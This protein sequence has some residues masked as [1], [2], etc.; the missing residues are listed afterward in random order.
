MITKL[1]L[2]ALLFSLAGCNFI[3]ASANTA[4]AVPP[5]LQYLTESDLE[6]ARQLAQAR[7]SKA[8]EDA[9]SNFPVDEF[10]CSAA[11]D[12]AA[13]ENIPFREL[14]LHTNAKLPDYH[15]ELTK[16]VFVSQKPLLTREECSR[17]I[18]L[19]DE[20]FEANGK[21]VGG[22]KWTALP[23]G[24]YKM[25]GF[26]LIDIPPIREFFAEV[27]RKRFLPIVQHTNP[28]FAESISD[29]ALDECYLM[30]FTPDTG[31]RMDI[32]ADDGCLSFTI[33]MN[34]KEEYEGGGTWFEGLAEDESNQ[35][36]GIV[37]MDVGKS[38]KREAELMFALLTRFQVMCTFDPAELGTWETQSARVNGMLWAGSRCIAPK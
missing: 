23:S 29:L 38:T 12:K 1:Y 32:H 24:E 4:K 31:K 16:S 20:H 2:L 6:A 13:V 8:V 30:K 17:I 35:A 9:L 7:H 37:K 34:P 36:A 18:R 14:K 15:D 27:F 26:K 33:Q 25:R 5:F 10:P 22:D 21:D 3:L 28:K 19:A 11:E